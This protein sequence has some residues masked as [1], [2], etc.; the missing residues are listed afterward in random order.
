MKKLLALLLAMALAITMCACGKKEETPTSAE[1]MATTFI[2]AYCTKDKLTYFPLYLHNERQRWEEQLL[3]DHGSE[4]A[5]CAVVQQQ[6]DE[7]GLSVEVHSFDDYLREFHNTYLNDAQAKYGDH[8]VS[9]ELTKSALMSAEE[10]ASFLESWK[11]GTFAAYVAESE[12]DKIT[13]AYAMTVTFRV[14]GT[15]TDYQETYQITVVLHDG[16]WKVATHSA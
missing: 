12:L 11:G 9:T 5:F 16:Q 13:E 3:K 6:A 8:T 1:E 14:D 7:K 10:L 4:E 15:I 2:R